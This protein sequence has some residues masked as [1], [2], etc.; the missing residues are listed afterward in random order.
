MVEKSTT[1][2]QYWSGVGVGGRALGNLI[3]AAMGSGGFRIMRSAFTF[4]RANHIPGDR[5]FIVG[6]SRG[7]FFA[8]HLA[9]M[10]A[11]LGLGRFAE[12]T[13]VEYRNQ[14]A[15][16]NR[17]ETRQ[18]VHFLGMFDCVPGNQI[19]LLRRSLQVLNHKQLEP[20][21]RNV[22]HAVSRDEKRW[23]Y[24]PLLF[25]NGGQATFEQAWFP[26]YHSDIGGDDNPPLNAFALWWMLREA[27]RHG[28]DFELIKCPEDAI[29]GWHHGKL[30]IKLG[31]MAD[32][33][34]TAPGIRSDWIT[35]RLGLRRTRM[36]LRDAAEVARQPLLEELDSCPRGC[37]ED[38]FE[39][40]LTP[41]GSRRL[42]KMLGH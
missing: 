23:T 21:I 35:T 36:A 16:R 7:A 24:A 17:T 9:G 11:R 26:G 29:G 28:L 34:S 15:A 18:D 25:S 40:F 41:E 4:V 12:E 22:A 5:I 37:A 1:V 3:D 38:M 31:F 19:Y 6:F 33:D 13:Y 42:T 20:G 8:R 30:G 27:Y 10:I 39:Y 14:V 32:I 2:A